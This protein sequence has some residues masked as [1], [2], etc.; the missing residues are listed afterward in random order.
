[1]KPLN[2]LNLKHMKKGWYMSNITKSEITQIVEA[3][4]LWKNLN[5]QIKKFGSRT[6]NFPECISEALICYQLDLD[7]H[8]KV[9]TNKPGDA[10]FNNQLIEI[11]ASSNFN[12]DL[13]SFS[14]NTKFD[15]L[16]FGRL[17]LINDKL[18]VYNMNMN[19]NQFMQLEVNSKESVSNQQESKRRPRLSLTKLIIENNISPIAI[20]DINSI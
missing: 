11:K 14:P 9:T 15:I 7:W 5:L 17:D 2:F 19:F 12:S 1:M 18:Y 10:S 20:I 6:T 8:N 13:T 3:Y 4:N 16:L